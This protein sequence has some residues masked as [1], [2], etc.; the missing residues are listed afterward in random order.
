MFLLTLAVSFPS[1]SNGIAGEV[2]LNDTSQILLLNEKAYDFYMKSMDDSCLANS[3]LALHLSVELMNSIK[4][5]KDLTYLN[6][7][8][9]LKAMSLEN[10][11]RSIHITD[12][13]RAL[14]TL[15]TA[16]LLTKEAGDKNEQASV[17][18]LIGLIHD[19]AY[20]PALAFNFYR[21]SL[22]LYRE[23]GNQEGQANQLLNIGIALRYLRNFGDALES[24]MESL[25]ISR[26][27]SDSTTMVEALLA[28]GFVYMFVEKY[29]D[30][31]KAQQEA[32]QIFVQMNDSTGIARI[33]ND[34]GVTNMS[35]GKLEVALEQHKAALKIRLKG[36]EYYYTSASYSY[37][38]S[39]CEDLKMFAEAITNYQAALHYNMLDGSQKSIIHTHLDMGSAYIKNSETDKAMDQFLTARELSQAE[40]Y[41]TAE[42]Q[43]AMYIAK[44]YLG[45]NQPVEAL[46]WL[47]KA[48]KVAPR[49]L[50][51]FL[52][53]LHLNMSNTY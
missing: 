53:D 21:T 40:N 27:I 20:Q 7:S 23:T 34:M 42:V 2:N 50:P 5:S 25:K 29:D 4:K 45:K 9:I 31:L 13:R 35:S 18:S 30:A 28:M 43:A 52:K 32:L 37:I 51:V 33:Y 19:Q 36:T 15:Q 16:L 22:E 10:I 8:K 49:P 11:A 1:L 47:K 44:I 26:Q 38:G 6:R 14:D 3:S 46:A 39:I 48:E 41:P 12:A 17:Y 24:I